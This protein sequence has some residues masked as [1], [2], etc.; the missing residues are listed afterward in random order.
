M[1][2]V[3]PKEGISVDTSTSNLACL[4][5]SC[6]LKDGQQTGWDQHLVASLVAAEVRRCRIKTVGPLNYV[7]HVLLTLDQAVL[8]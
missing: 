8:Q 7:W 3:S 1:P 6:H 5:Y 4:T 2:V